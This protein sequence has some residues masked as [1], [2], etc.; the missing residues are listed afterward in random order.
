M[1]NVL[2]IISLSLLGLRAISQNYT[3]YLTG[4]LV[5]SNTFPNKG[6]ALFG[7]ATDNTMAMKWFLQRAN[8][9]DVLVLRLTGADE[10][11]TY[12]N[13][14]GIAVNSI[15]TIVLNNPSAVSDPYIIGKIDSA[16][17]I[18]FADGNQADYFST[19]FNTSVDSAIRVGVDNRKIALGGSGAGMSVLGGIYFTEEFGP[20]TSS[21]ALSNPFDSLV[22]LSTDPFLNPYGIH[23]QT[24]FEGN[25]DNPDKKGRH[26]VFLALLLKDSLY[27]KGILCDEM[28][29]VC[30]DE[31]DIA[32]V[33]GGAPNSDDNVYFIQTNC[34]LSE[35]YP[36]VMDIN[37]PL[38]WKRFD[39]PTKVCAFKAGQQSGQSFDLNDWK[40]N[41]GGNWEHWWVE[42]GQLVT[43]LGT[44]PICDTASIAE[45][46]FEFFPNPV[47]EGKLYMTLIENNRVDLFNTQ[48]QRIPIVYYD[49][50]IDLNSVQNGIYYLSVY[51]ES[52]RR[53]FKIVINN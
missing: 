27:A 11:N 15:E 31:L 46:L 33:Y 18:F 4:S 34:E 28:A 17:A 14:M 44:A 9:G 13:S 21:A 16:E 50:A 12:M 53:T 49:N 36:E 32:H 1:K 51:T 48:G 24:I 40:T 39:K 38:T 8:G 43:G 41:V 47:T 2:L 20:L 22:Q 25:I 26:M 52:Q 7:G 3:S 30:I 37:T 6:L 45:I 23:K 42:A 19:F 29:A 35:L 10:Y 5:N